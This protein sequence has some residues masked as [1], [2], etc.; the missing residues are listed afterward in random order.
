MAPICSA[1]QVNLLVYHYLKESGFNHAC[2][3]LR[4]EGRLDDEPLSREAVIE[5][6]QLVKVLQKGLLYLAVEAHVNPDGTEKPCSAP[7]SLVGPPHVCDGIP[8]PTPAQEFIAPPRMTPTPPP[9]PVPSTKVDTAV[10]TQIDRT[11]QSRESSAALTTTTNSPLRSNGTNLRRESDNYL[12]VASSSKSKLD[13]TVPFERAET[14]G[15]RKIGAGKLSKGDKRVKR[16]TT[17]QPNGRRGTSEEEADDSES[18]PTATSKKNK[19]VVE[20]SKG[21]AG[22]S[23][24]NGVAAKSG[25]GKGAGSNTYIPPL[26]GK[27]KGKEVSKG[28]VAKL[29]GHSA[30]VFLSAWNPTVPGLLASGAGDATVRIWDLGSAIL[31]NGLE[32]AAESI[33]PAVCKHL[34]STHAKDVSALSW[35]P[36]GTLLASGSYDGILR[37]WTPQGDLHLVMSMHQGPIFAV[38]WNRKGNFILSGSADGTVIVWDL[39]SGKV[40]QQFSLHSDSVLDI[41]W[42][43]GSINFKG[44]TPSSAADGTFATCSADNSINLLRLGES[45]PIKILKGHTDEVNA[46]RFDPTGTLLASVSDDMTAR[47]WNLEAIL[48]SNYVGVSNGRSGP[49]RSRSHTLGKRSS[50]TPRPTRGGSADQMELDDQA[51]GGGS[52]NND[53]DVST[54][55]DSNGGNTNN[56]ANGAGNSIQPCKFVLSG[57]KKDIFAIAWAHQDFGSEE[58]RLLATASFDNT[59]RIWNADDGTC[60]RIFQE[61]TDSVYSV[62]FSPDRRFLVTGGMDH[63][64]FISSVATGDIALAHAGGGGIFDIAWH[65]NGVKKAPQNTVSGS[66]TNSDKIKQEGEAANDDDGNADKGLQRRHHLALSQADRTLTILDVSTSL[67]LAT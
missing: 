4:H 66:E 46:I 30:E 50:V 67:D 35:N 25:A 22:F 34:P 61:H 62:C 41:D 5:P 11:S 18:V 32:S 36:D 57:H 20:A 21:S 43:T 65:V 9:R 14:T 16:T 6:G 24:N 47:V 8:R 27:A 59:A 15:K 23:N 55:L 60:L 26:T 37:L 29:K 51:E 2:F 52:N 39:G 64:L 45:K 63:R 17:P 56:A 33:T 38:R 58:P 13:V 19:S 44:A 53:E 12:N 54:G 31:S 42:L 7:F 1:S 49:N 3:S 28:K 40:R 10:Q 48:G